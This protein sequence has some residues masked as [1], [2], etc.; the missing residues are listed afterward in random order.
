[1]CQAD[2]GVDLPAVATFVV[3]ISRNFF[4]IFIWWIIFKLINYLF[5][6]CLLKQ[7]APEIVVE[8]SW[9]HTGLG[10]L[11]ELA[12]TVYAHPAAQV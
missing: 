12:C 7:D 5:L 3:E 1:M 8:H 4:K 9:V 2:N 10:S 11:T 6:F